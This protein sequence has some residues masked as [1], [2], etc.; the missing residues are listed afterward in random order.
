MRPCEAAILRVPRI[1]ASTAAGSLAGR[2]PRR[3]RAQLTC[4]SH[5]QLRSQPPQGRHRAAFLQRLL[6]ELPARPPSPLPPPR[7]NHVGG[8]ERAR[9]A[10]DDHGRQQ[11]ARRVPQSD[12][13]A[14][15]DRQAQLRRGLPR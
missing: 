11:D 10:D 4:S 13:G 7:R 8:G 9:A 2:S 15:R 6:Q 5:P 14:A 12:Q 3:T 1:L